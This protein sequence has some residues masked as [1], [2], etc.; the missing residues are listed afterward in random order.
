[1]SA[2]LGL[3][4]KLITEQ[5]SPVALLEKGIDQAFF[6]K[7]EA[8]AFAF[9]RSHLASYGEM[10]S[11]RTVESELDLTFPKFP[12][13]HLDYW[14]TKVKRRHQTT[15][16]I[17]ATQDIQDALK[18]NDVDGAGE[19]A[20][21]VSAALQ[22]TGTAREELFH[23]S[24]LAD[25]VVER[26]DRQQRST[27]MSGI[28]FGIPYLDSI[29][30]G[31]QPGDTVAIVGRPGVGKSYLLLQMALDAWRAGYTP[32]F[33]SMEM[34]PVQCARRILALLSGVNVTRIRVGR[35]GF[36][37]RKKLVTD[38]SELKQMQDGP[39][40]LLLGGSLTSTVED[41]I[42]R[43][44]DL[45][46]DIVFVDGAYLLRTN[47]KT[48]AKWE[49]VAETAELLKI[50]AHEFQLPIV[51]SYQFN[52]RGPGSLANI[53]MSDVIGQL[54]S[55]VLGIE[56]ELTEEEKQDRKANR[57]VIRRTDPNQ[58]KVLEILKGR[59]GEQGKLR[60]LYNI[61]KMIIRQVSVIVGDESGYRRLSASACK[62]RSR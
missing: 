55:I 19:I 62:R 56:D 57:Q 43:I 6:V 34:P 46:P 22:L 36:F 39:R 5:V 23:L 21:Q 3:L 15:L 51:E 32:L 24:A 38:I 14:I 41:L 59:E 1:M 2:G 11:L 30:D 52:R 48:G 13:E 26:H 10:P 18:D 25:R 4:H 17:K 9:I 35:L 54:A 45:R 27:V 12:D 29:S 60:I 42:L 40:F 50:M 31:A 44:R 53:G 7:D 20:R 28:P 8:R 37:G 61:Q 47:S 33:V 49:R 58:H 16:L